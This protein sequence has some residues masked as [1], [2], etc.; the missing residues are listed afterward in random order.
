MADKNTVSVHLSEED[1]KLLEKRAEQLKK[2]WNISKVSKSDVLRNA[3]KVV[4][5]ITE[6][7]GE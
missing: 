1:A 2:Q 5:N 7:D 6:G 3:L 4:T